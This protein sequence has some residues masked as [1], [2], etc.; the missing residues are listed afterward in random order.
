MRLCR[1]LKNDPPPPAGTLQFS[2]STYTVA[3][4]GTSLLAT[5]TRTGGSFGAVSVDYS[6]ADGSATASADYGPASGTLN[7]ADGVLS[8]TFS[9]TILDD[10]TYEGDETFSLDLSNPVGGASLGTP[11]SATVTITEND[12]VPPAGSLQFSGATYAVAENGTSLLVTVTRTGGSFGTVGVDY[13]S[14]DGSATAGS[15]YAA[16]SGTLSFADGVLSQTFSVTILNDTTYEGDETFS[17]GLSNVTGGATL[18]APSSA[19]VTIGEDD[20]RPP[21][22]SLQFSNATYTVLRTGTHGR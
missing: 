10:T 3:E 22:G 16:A 15:D 2:G 14:S 11:A 5:V 9:V 8:Q 6:A 4:D 21:A 18:G 7:F 19:T 20:P 13:T 12:P 17:L 1:L